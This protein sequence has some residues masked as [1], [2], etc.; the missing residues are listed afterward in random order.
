MRFRL[1]S[2]LK[3]S[4]VINNY[5][6]GRFLC[7]AVDSALTQFE[8][9]DELVLVDDGST[10]D[11]ASVIEHYL[12]D[13]RVRVIQ[14]RNQ[15]QLAAVLNGLAATT[16]DLL[17]LLD[18]DDYFLPGY[19]ERLRGLAEEHPEIDM[20]FSAA[21]PGGPRP[22]EVQEMQNLLARIAIPEGPTGPSRWSTLIG[23]EFLGVPTSG[24]ALNRQLVQQLLS[25]RHHFSDHCRIN[26]RVLRLLRVNPASH[27]ATR[28]SADGLLVRAASVAG[29]LKYSCTTPGFYYRVHGTN[30][31]AMMN[32]LGRRYIDL[33]R[34][35]QTARMLA[36][37]F[38]LQRR[39][40]LEELLAEIRQRSG[41][42]KLR[43]RMRLTLNYSFAL[44]IAEGPLPARLAAIAALPVQWL[45]LS[46]TRRRR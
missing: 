2:T 34:R 10:D 6:Y 22:G 41:A 14:Q 1:V 16:G 45:T 36:R 5:N 8:P 31:F 9:G 19:L 35:Q 25:V 13:T 33:K 39:P 12:Q 37:A 17:L 43:R 23:G 24:I 27:V 30:A 44:L 20:F 15:G 18:S 40:R 26:Q 32:R 21:L 11:S 29:A 46:S 28:L 38:E 42:R 7:E 3:L 4:V